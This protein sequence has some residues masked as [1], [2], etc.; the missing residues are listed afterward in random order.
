MAC[1]RQA[2]RGGGP[3]CSAAEPHV[4]RFILPLLSSNREGGRD[5]VA[6]ANIGPQDS[7]A[8]FIPRSRLRAPCWHGRSP[9]S[10][11]LGT[12]RRRS[13]HPTSP[14]SCSVHWW[15]VTVA[16]W[17]PSLWAPSP[18]G[19]RRQRHGGLYGQ[20]DQ[21]ECCWGSA[22]TTCNWCPIVQSLPRRSGPLQLGMPFPLLSEV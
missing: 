22:R 21:S 19:R 15:V 2:N 18:S 1:L 6:P 20:A 9:I 17:P 12:D 8:Y 3:K 5:G 13:T 4:L 7:A 14:S 10:F 16:G 11:V